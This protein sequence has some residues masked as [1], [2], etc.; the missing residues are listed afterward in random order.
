MRILISGL[1]FENNVKI[2]TVNN[3]TKRDEK[4]PFMTPFDFESFPA[5]RPMIS[6]DNTDNMYQKNF[7]FSF[8][9][10]YLVIKKAEI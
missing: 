9:M 1:K 10:S 3:D 4:V 8:G 7:R 2:Q 5:K 6:P